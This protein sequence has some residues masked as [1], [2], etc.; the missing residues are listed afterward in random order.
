MSGV[1]VFYP[2]RDQYA[3]IVDHLSSAEHTLE[4]PYVGNMLVEIASGKRGLEGMEY[5]L[6]QVRHADLQHHVRLALAPALEHMVLAMSDIY[7]LY[8]RVP[9]YFDHWTSQGDL[10]VLVMA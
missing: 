7:S 2:F 4:M 1:K 3:L 8:G 10:A 9:L 5:M 6:L